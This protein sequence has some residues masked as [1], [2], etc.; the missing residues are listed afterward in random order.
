MAAFLRYGNTGPIAGGG[1]SGINV[2]FVLTTEEASKLL[3]HLRGV[4]LKEF[5]R[6]A[7]NA[8]LDDE[9]VLGLTFSSTSCPF[10]AYDE[11]VAKQYGAPY[12]ESILTN[13]S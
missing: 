3:N 11:A 9:N 6:P 8:F 1:A 13:L 5:F 4:S 2:L 7:L 12:V 10:D